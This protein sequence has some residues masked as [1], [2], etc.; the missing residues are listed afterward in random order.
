MRKFDRI[1]FALS[2]ILVA[3]FVIAT[4]ISVALLLTTIFSQDEPTDGRATS[5]ANE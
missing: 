1:F 3:A 2:K 5:H 4:L